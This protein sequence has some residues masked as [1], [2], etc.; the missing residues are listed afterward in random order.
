M[1]WWITETSEEDIKSRNIPKYIQKYI[2]YYM[3]LLKSLGGE[4]GPLTK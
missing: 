4:D 3:W 1:D 2:I